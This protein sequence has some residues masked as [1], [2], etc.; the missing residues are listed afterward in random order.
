VGQLVSDAL[1]TF[2]LP[3]QRIEARRD[4]TGAVDAEVPGGTAGGRPAHRAADR[5]D[6]RERPAVDRGVGLSFSAFHSA[7]HSDFHR[8]P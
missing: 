6:L 2:A 3:G 5:V 7:F 1:R 8:D 4:Q